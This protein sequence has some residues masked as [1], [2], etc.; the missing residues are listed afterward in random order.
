MRIK[1]YW[2]KS[3][4]VCFALAAIFLFERTGAAGKPDNT[5]Y[6]DPDNKYELLLPTNWRP[7]NYQD[8]AGN[9]RCDIVYRDR[10][11]GLLKITQEK[12][13]DPD[14]DNLIRTEIDQN[15]RFRPGYVFSG[16]ERFVGQYAGGKLLE[17]S[18]SHAGQPKK[19]RNYYLKAKGETVWVLRFAGDR[20]SMGPLR[21]E[22]DQIARSFKPL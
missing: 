19:A 22:T 14:L 9:T 11:Y 13:S 6:H 18:F 10:T 4:L 17:F 21:N 5:L 3:F 1:N 8:G 12:P 2:F 7:V 16:T 15:L 20:E